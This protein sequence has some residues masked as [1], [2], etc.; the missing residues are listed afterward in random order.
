[1]EKPQRCDCYSYTHK[2]GIHLYTAEIWPLKIDQCNREDMLTV[3]RVARCG[4][5]WS[6]LRHTPVTLNILTLA[7]ADGLGA[8]L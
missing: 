8:S 2:H 4:G 3:P 7:A 1:M 5:A 6:S